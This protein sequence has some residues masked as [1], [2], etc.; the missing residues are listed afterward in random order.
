[1]GAHGDLW[2][3]MGPL[4]TSRDLCGPMGI[5]GDLWGLFPDSGCLVFSIFSIL[6]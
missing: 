4:G 1:M 2:G 3:P 5:S 6:A